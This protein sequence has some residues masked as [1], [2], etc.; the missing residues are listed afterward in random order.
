MSWLA[1][2]ILVGIVGM[3]LFLGFN[4]QAP[5]DKPDDLKR[6]DDEESGEPSSML[7]RYWPPSA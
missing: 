3:V 1:I 4:R 7:G 2:L 5:D 6:A